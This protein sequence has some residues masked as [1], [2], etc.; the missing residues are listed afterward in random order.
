MRISSS[1]AVSAATAA[2][3]AASLIVAPAASAQTA[4]T[5]AGDQASE[6]SVR[7]EE[8][9][10]KAKGS[11]DS[12]TTQKRTGI[13][14]PAEAL[15]PLSPN[16]AADPL[17]INPAENPL[18]EVSSSEMFLDWT[19]DM[20]E[21]AGKDFVQAWAIG[22]AIPDTANPVELLKQEIQG[23]T[24][25][26]SGLFTG[27]FAQSS[28]GSSQATSVILPVFLGV[29]VIGQVIEWLMRGVR[30]ITP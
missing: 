17:Y 26:S 18:K 21:G 29:I 16:P 20:E 5:Q 19:S 14:A 11:T 13:G 7:A 22:S 23:S 27:D 2:V 1:A 8:A 25:M 28:R 6:S 10:N 4:D 24:M 3:L 30:F 9:W 15:Q 12:S